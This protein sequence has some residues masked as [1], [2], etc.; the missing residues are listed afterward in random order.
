MHRRFGKK[1]QNPWFKNGMGTLAPDIHPWFWNN[2]TTLCQ[3]QPLRLRTLY[4]RC[5]SLPFSDRPYTGEIFLSCVHLLTVRWKWQG[6]TLLAGFNSPRVPLNHT[7]FNPHQLIC[8]AERCLDS[9]CSL[10]GQRKNLCHNSANRGSSLLQSFCKI[11]KQ[12]DILKI[13]IINT[14]I[15]KY[16]RQWDES[17]SYCHPKVKRYIFE[18]IRKVCWFPNNLLKILH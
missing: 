6:L 7:W 8:E 16:E 14:K 10:N 4:T 18:L 2:N 12:W 17:F 15:W 5:L 1:V 3:Q 9:S 11:L 13:I